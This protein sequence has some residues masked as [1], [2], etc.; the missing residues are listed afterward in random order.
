MSTEI[1]RLYRSRSERMVGGV[2]G[3]LGEFLGMDPTVVRLI[4]I[5]ITFFWPFTPL[6]YLLLML[7][8]PES[9]A[10]M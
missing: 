4:A 10:E 8:V 1:R 7:V 5:F 2:C 6:V 3:G 9:H